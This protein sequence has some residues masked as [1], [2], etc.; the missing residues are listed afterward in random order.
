MV[1]IYQAWRLMMRDESQLFDNWNEI[2]KS[3]NSLQKNINIK[4]GNIYLVS[5]G[6]NIGNETYGKGDIFLRPVL[7]IKK[8][9][10]NYFIGIPLTSKE[11]N[12][13]YFFKFFYKDKPSYAMFNQI[14]TIN[15]K[16]ILK[17]HGKANKKDFENL[18]EEFIRFLY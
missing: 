6:K 8:L 9:G 13:S 18:K 14:R 7:V 3:I 11:K 15:S 5:I 10:H 1:E 12:G 4:E 16:R 17:Y 2:K